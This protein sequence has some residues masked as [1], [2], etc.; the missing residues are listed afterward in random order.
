MQGVGTLCN[1]WCPRRL[2]AKLGCT[3]QSCAMTCDA[4]GTVHLIARHFLQVNGRSYRFCD[5]AVVLTGNGDLTYRP[6]AFGHL[7]LQHG[8]SQYLCFLCSCRNGTGTE[9]KTEGNQNQD[10]E[11]Q[12]EGVEEMIIVGRSAHTDSKMTGFL[13][14]QVTKTGKYSDLDA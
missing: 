11:N 12:H 5:S 7:G 3:G 2:I 8:V 14:G 4:Y 10:A 9:V 13:Y 6:D 1:T